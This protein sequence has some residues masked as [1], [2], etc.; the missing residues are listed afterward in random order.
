MHLPQIFYT[1]TI[2][3]NGWEHLQTILSL[4]NN[5]NTNLTNSP[6]HTYL[7]YHY[8]IESVKNKLWKNPKLS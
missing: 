5:K 2:N 3:E 6:L 7:H 1:T 4:T 8:Q